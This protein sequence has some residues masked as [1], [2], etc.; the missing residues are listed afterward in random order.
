MSV[1]DRLLPWISVKSVD[2]GQYVCQHCRTQH[3]MR[4]QSCPE[5]GSFCFDR[6]DWDLNE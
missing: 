6:V 4:Y 3:E 5:C 2:D 1:V